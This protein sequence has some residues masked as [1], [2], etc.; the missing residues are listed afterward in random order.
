MLDYLVSKC[1]ALISVQRTT[2]NKGKSRVTVW[3]KQWMT[4]G[5][6]QQSVQLWVEAV[7]A[8]EKAGQVRQLCW[9]PSPRTLHT[10]LFNVALISQILTVGS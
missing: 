1:E 5:K 8:E 3:T 10:K 2:K 6:A 4:Q 7:S 9:T